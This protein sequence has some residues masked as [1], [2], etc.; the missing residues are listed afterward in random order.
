MRLVG[1]FRKGNKINPTR[2][3]PTT[4]PI[5]KKGKLKKASSFCSNQL[6]DIKTIALDRYH[7][8]P[9]IFTDSASEKFE[10]KMKKSTAADITSKNIKLYY[11]NRTKA[12]AY[13]EQEYYCRQAM[14]FNAGINAGWPNIGVAVGNRFPFDPWTLQPAIA[15]TAKICS[16]SQW[17]TWVSCSTQWSSI[18]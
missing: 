15:M 5:R 14:N 17:I 4:K 13:W 18:N 1:R 7:S 12:L 6:S 3:L 8:A 10:K 16:I 9:G 2:A 11:K